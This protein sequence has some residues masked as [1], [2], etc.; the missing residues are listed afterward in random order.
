MT[1][2]LEGKVALITGGAS[3]LGEATVRLFVEEGARVVISDLQVERGEALASE[4]GAAAIFQRTSSPASLYSR[5]WP[6]MSSTSRC[7][8][9]QS[10]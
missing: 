3:G 7:A 8:Y 1:D 2:R 4:L 10:E 5:H 6:A 9:H